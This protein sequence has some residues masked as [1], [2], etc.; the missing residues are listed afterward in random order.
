[1]SYRPFIISRNFNTLHHIAFCPFLH[2]F[3]SMIHLLALS[4]SIYFPPETHLLKWSMISAHMNKF[5]NQPMIL[6]WQAIYNIYI[7]MIFYHH[8]FK[9]KHTNIMINMFNDRLIRQLKSD[10]RTLCKRVN[11][12]KAN[13]HNV[14]CKEKNDKLILQFRLTWCHPILC[15]LDDNLSLEVHYTPEPL[16]SHLKNYT[17]PPQT[18]RP[19][20]ITQQI[21]EMSKSNNLKLWKN[22]CQGY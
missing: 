20:N 8:Y 7:N 13:D 6:T 21:E 17:P 12:N 18:L 15:D 14:E 22:I 10:Y 4:L 5:Q 3:W 16:T 1:M 2:P 11:A 19:R 9:Y